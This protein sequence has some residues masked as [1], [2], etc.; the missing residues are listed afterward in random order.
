MNS[1]IQSHF[2]LHALHNSRL[3]GNSLFQQFGSNANNE[4]EVLRYRHRRSIECES[5]K[6][7]FRET[8]RCKLIFGDFSAEINMLSVHFTRCELVKPAMRSLLWEQ[9]NLLTDSEHNPF[10]AKIA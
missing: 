8:T 4:L 1:E 9:S 3:I 7:I 6:R 2:N 5:R 10:Q